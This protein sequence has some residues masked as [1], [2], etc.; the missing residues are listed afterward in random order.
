MAWQAEVKAWGLDYTSLSAT[1]T[2]EYYDDTNRAG[3]TYTEQVFVQPTPGTTAQQI[4]ALQVKV[5]QRGQQVRSI[6]QFKDAALTNV[7]VGTTIA[8]P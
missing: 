3:T 8:I 7:P 6:R 2:I 5:Q 4:A 1:A